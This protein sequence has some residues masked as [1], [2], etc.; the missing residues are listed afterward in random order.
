MEN[1]ALQQRKLWVVRGE[2][3]C[4]CGMDLGIE[5][6]WIEWIDLLVECT[7]K[8]SVQ[9]PRGPQLGSKRLAH[10][11]ELSRC[12]TK[13]V[14]IL[15]YSSI[16]IVLA[17]HTA[18]KWSYDVPSFIKRSKR[19]QCIFRTC[20]SSWMTWRSFCMIPL[21]LNKSSW[22]GSDEATTPW[23][24]TLGK[25]RR[26]PTKITAQT[27]STRSSARSF[28]VG[29][30]VCRSRLKIAPYRKCL[31]SFPLFFFCRNGDMPGQLSLNPLCPMLGSSPQPPAFLLAWRG[32]ALGQC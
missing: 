6:K 31:L 23:H 18:F 2:K 15:H 11:N 22:A 32:Q 24:A 13:S 9:Y 8:V 25:T 30:A 20:T 17:S 10:L 4:S 5:M 3:E 29:V 12:A 28:S 26:K 16:S 14:M 19:G 7:V 27:A 21:C 1:D